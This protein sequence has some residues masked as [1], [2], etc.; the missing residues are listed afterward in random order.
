MMIEDFDFIEKYM[1][2]TILYEREIHQ[3]LNAKKMQT[4]EVQINT[5]KAL[6]VDSI[7]I[8]YTFFGKE[9]SSSETAFNKSVKESSLDC[10]IKYVH[11]VKYK[12]SKAKER[13]M[14]YLRPLHSHLQVLSKEDLRGTRIEHGLKRAFM[15]LFDIKPVYDEE[16]MAEVQLTDE[17]NVFAIGQQHVEQPEL[18]N[19]DR[20]DQDAIQC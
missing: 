11:A 7:I 8:E 19:E 9:N 20:V 17:C 13:C 6:D 16:P 5:V 3:L 4:Q 1:I 15:S 2:E 18:I 14:T 12:M 10:E